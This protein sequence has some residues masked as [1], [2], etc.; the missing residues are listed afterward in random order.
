MAT[1]KPCPFC[2]GNA[3]FSRIP[4][5]GFSLLCQRCGAMAM[6]NSNTGRDALEDAWNRRTARFSSGAVKPCPFCGSSA[7]LGKMPHDPSILL[8]T[9]CNM[10]VSFVKSNTTP[11]SLNYWNQRV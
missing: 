1:L 9:N 10:M 4:G 3:S 2:G 11:T 6:L 5:Q 8:C 7:A